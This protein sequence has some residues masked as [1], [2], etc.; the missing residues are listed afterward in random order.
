[1]SWVYHIGLHFG[2]MRVGYVI[3]TLVLGL[4]FINFFF[5]GCDFGLRE[6]ERVCVCVCVCFFNYIFFSLLIL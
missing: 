4:F 1:M 3:G 5:Y 2:K 6:R